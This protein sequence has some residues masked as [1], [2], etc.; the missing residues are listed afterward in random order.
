MYLCELLLRHK[1]AE[2]FLGF[3][4]LTVVVYGELYLLGYN[5]M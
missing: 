1:S 2:S 4:V 3:E 5:A